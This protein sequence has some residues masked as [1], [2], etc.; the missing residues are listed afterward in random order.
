MAMNTSDGE[1]TEPR[2]IA[3]P[4]Y[5]EDLDETFHGPFINE[6]DESYDDAYEEESTAIL[7]GRDI[8][9]PG[10]SGVVPSG[11][12]SADTQRREKL[13]RCS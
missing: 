8:T 3:V 11:G 5:E 10:S 13:E 9:G 12:V 1:V 4:D 6:L 7:E 2:L